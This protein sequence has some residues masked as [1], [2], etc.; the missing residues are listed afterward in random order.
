MFSKTVTLFYIQD[1]RGE[2]IKSEPPAEKFYKK[3]LE[4]DKTFNFGAFK[5]Y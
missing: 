5:C 4:I 1:Y 3:Y 2:K